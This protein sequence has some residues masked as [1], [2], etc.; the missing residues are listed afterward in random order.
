MKPQGGVV[1]CRSMGQVRMHTFTGMVGY[2][3]KDLQKPHLRWF[4]KGVEAEEIAEVRALHAQY[5]QGEL[6]HRVALTP[7]NMFD[8]AYVYMENFVADREG[9]SLPHTLLRMLATGRYYPSATWVVPKSGSR[10]E[11]GRAMAIWQSMK[12]PTSVTL[13]DI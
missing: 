10:M 1:M 3:M 9:M 5:G 8:R 2:C 13:D 12:E 6:K 7:V 4:A 11:L